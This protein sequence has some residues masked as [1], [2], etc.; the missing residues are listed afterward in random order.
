MDLHRGVCLAVT[1]C[2]CV[3]AE[4]AQGVE[5]ARKC[6]GGHGYL[7]A[8]GLPLLYARYV[9]ACTYEGE[10][11]VLLQQTARFLL[12]AVQHAAAGKTLARSVQV[13]V[14]RSCPRPALTVR[15]STWRMR[16]RAGWL[17]RRSRTRRPCDSPTRTWPCCASA[18]PAWLSVCGLLV[19]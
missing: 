4:R 13:G 5:E 19:L 6:C 16:S 12:K 9:P 7:L 17:H 15:R 8:S 18:P 14:F 3:G 10:N 11:Y 2:L 1:L